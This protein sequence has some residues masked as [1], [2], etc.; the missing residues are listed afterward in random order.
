ME[1]AKEYTKVEKIVRLSLY[2]FVG[3]I[4]IVLHKILFLPLITDIAE[5]PHC[6]EILGFSAVDYFW[7]LIFIGI[8][9]SAFIIASVVMLPIGFKGIKEGR[10][11]PKSVKVYKPTVVRTG[12]I[13]YFKS[14]VHVLL[15]TMILMLSIWGYHQV[16]NMPPID[17]QRLDINLCQEN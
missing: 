17:K 16:E 4:L 15:P 14:G 5:N 9:A 3:F 12:V 1:Y 10:F 6:Y 2:A 8:P 13:A 11:P 7:H